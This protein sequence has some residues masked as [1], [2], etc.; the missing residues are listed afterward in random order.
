MLL[1][2]MFTVNGHVPARTNVAELGV[3]MWFKYPI[4][5]DVMIVM[6]GGEGLVRKHQH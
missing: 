6:V 5:L 4:T 1:I 3:C 2:L